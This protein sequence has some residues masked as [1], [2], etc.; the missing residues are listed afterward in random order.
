V[1]TGRALTG[2]IAALALVLAVGAGHAAADGTPCPASNSPNELVLASGSGQTTQIGKPFPQNLQVRLANSNG[3]PLTGTLAGVDVTFA[4][5]ASG[6]GGLFSS[7]GSNVAVVGTDEQGTATAPPLTAN[8]TIGDF[9]VVAQSAYGSVTLHLAVTA[10]GVPAAI[11]VAGA[12]DQDASVNGRYAQPLRA[13]VTDANGNPVQGVTV[14]FGVVPGATG[15][16]ASFLGGQPTATTDASGVATSPPLLANGTPGRFTATASTDGVASVAT[17][18]LRNESVAVSIAA[19]SAARQAA[20]VGARFRQ[21]LRVRVLDA[22]GHPIEGATVAF[23][24]VPSGGGA[25]GAFAGGATQATATT[26][27]DGRAASPL[28]TANTSAGSFTATAST[29]G[30]ARSVTYALTNRAARPTALTAGAASGEHAGV[31]SRFPIPFAVTVVDAHGNPVKGATVTFAAPAHGPSGHFRKASRVV[32]VATSSKG[33]AIAPRFTANRKAGG[34]A[35]TA[36]VSGA[37]RVAFALVNE[38]RG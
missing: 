36:A 18:A 15:A 25:G 2:G 32:R 14:T 35:V 12:A 17:Y 22:S 30:S 37:K 19:T 6:A 5:S 29:A 31:G 7:T 8:D 20:K 3:C 10:S 33:I 24:I 27:A 11:D 38:P 28:V 1:K 4:T 13:R 9:T 26:D 16:G 34:Y 23:T 21:P